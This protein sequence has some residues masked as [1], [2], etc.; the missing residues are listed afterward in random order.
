[1]SLWNDISKLFLCPISSQVEIELF[2]IKGCIVSVTLHV[3]LSNSGWKPHGALCVWSEY[4]DSSQAF[5]WWK[6]KG[7]RSHYLVIAILGLELFYLPS[8]GKKAGLMYLEGHW[9]SDPIPIL[10]PRWAQHALHDKLAPS[11]VSNFP[12]G[13]RTVLAQWHTD[14]P[15]PLGNALLLLS[16]VYV[17]IR[18]LF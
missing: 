18:M 16:I 5:A 2:V 3:S 8:S 6:E 7:T 4:T 9:F 14:P 13:Y 11:A 17:Y 10:F 12:T 1:M 15:L